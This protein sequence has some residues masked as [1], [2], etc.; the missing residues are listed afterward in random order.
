MVLSKWSQQ[1]RIPYIAIGDRNGT[2]EAFGRSHWVQSLQEVIKS[3]SKVTAVS[4]CV[5]GALISVQLESAF[6]G[7]EGN[8]VVPFKPH[9]LIGLAINRRPCNSLKT[10]FNKPRDLPLVPE[11]LQ[12]SAAV[13]EAWLRHLQEGRR[14]ADQGECHT[15]LCANHPILQELDGRSQEQSYGSPT[16]FSMGIVQFYRPP[17]PVWVWVQRSRSLCALAAPCGSVGGHGSVV[18]GLGRGFWNWPGAPPPPPV[19]LWSTALALD[20]GPGLGPSPL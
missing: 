5:D 11:N 16:A 12:Q 17:P 3:T 15:D 6:V 8:D 10:V 13:A 20:L 19:V 14:Q 9:S 18:L 7:I 2:S 1:C 4:R